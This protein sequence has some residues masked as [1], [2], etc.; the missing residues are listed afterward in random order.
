MLAM[1]GAN[2]Q[3]LPLPPSREREAWLMH[4]AGAFE[5]AVIG[6]TLVSTDHRRLTVNRAFCEFLGYPEEELLAR[7]VCDLIHPDDV[8]EDWRQLAMLL[9]GKKDSYRREKR[10]LHRDGQVLWGDFSCTLARDHKGQPLFFITQVLDITERKRAERAVRESEERFRSLTALSSDWYWEQDA[11]FRFTRFLSNDATPPWRANHDELIGRRRWE[12]PGAQPIEGSWTRHRALLEAHL[13]YRDFEYVDTQSRGGPRFVAVSG[14]PVFDAE[15]RYVGYRGTARDISAGKRAEQ[16]LRDTQA[17]LRLA[18]EVGR[19]GAWAWDVGAATLAWSEEACAIFETKPGFAPRPKE[20]LSFVAPEYR[21]AVRST[22]KECLRGGSPFDIELE[23]FT[24]RG[25]RLCIRLICEAEWDARGRVHRL[26]G[27]L[28]DVSESKA[29]Q[30]EILRLNAQLEERVQKR[31]AQLE[32]A[33][34]ELEAFSYSI[35]H[36]LR[37][38]LSSIDGFSNSLQ[39]SAAA[40]L[41]DRSHHYLRRIRAGVRQMS[42][43]TDGLLSLASLSRADLRDE[44]VDLADVARASLASCQEQSPQRS[45]DAVVADHLPARGDPRLLAQVIGNLVGNAWKFTSRRPHARIEVGGTRDPEGQWVYFVRDDGAGFDMAYASKMFEAFRR[46][47]SNA[48]F[49]GTGIGLA[50]THRI[51]TRHGGRI[52]AE[53]APDRGATFYF[54]LG[55][56][57]AAQQ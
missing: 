3:F 11:E 45:V 15:G 24:A 6:M 40:V 31:T 19:L 7:A 30:A 47:H 33:N 28:Q 52:W 35:A 22:V 8:N 42:E 38:P 27:A 2:P 16:R 57:A 48:E 1:N 32:A 26:Q 41:D 46:M 34:R 13:P 25:R 29:A 17:M 49:E 18:A 55:A 23:V 20:A 5:N 43:L 39:S 12:L 53:A 56:W 44:P 21:R 37:A 14:Q 36:D 51:V 9:A 54:T 50:I 10:Y 4:F